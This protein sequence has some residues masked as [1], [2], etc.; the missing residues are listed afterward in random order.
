MYTHVLIM[1]GDLSGQGEQIGERTYARIQ[2]AAGM[3][4]CTKKVVF[5]TAATRTAAYPAMPSD[6]SVMMAD[7]L[8]TLVPNASIRVLLGDEEWSS[9]GELRKFFAAVPVGEPVVFISGAYHLR[10][11]RKMVRTYHREYV[12]FVTYEPV[13]GDRLTLIVSGFE[14]LKWILTSLPDSWQRPLRRMLEHL[15]GR[16][17]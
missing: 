17:L 2:H 1:S 4:T 11:L 9:R 6:M 15:R 10:R 3:A 8:T 14:S 16:T 5:Y 12:P 7:V 13:L